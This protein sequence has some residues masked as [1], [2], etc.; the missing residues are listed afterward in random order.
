MINVGV[1]NTSN[2]R[3]SATQSGNISWAIV[4]FPNTI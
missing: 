3:V 1:S 2:L 4:Y